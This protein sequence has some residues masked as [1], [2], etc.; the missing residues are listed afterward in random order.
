[1][2]ME[3]IV[4]VSRKIAARKYEARDIVLD[5]DEIIKAIERYVI[6]NHLGQLEKIDEISFVI[7]RKDY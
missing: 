4:E 3:L 2:K 5:Q 7:K 1:M 6:S